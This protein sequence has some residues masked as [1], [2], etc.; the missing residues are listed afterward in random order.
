MQSL[1]ARPET[2]RPSLRDPDEGQ[3][4]DRNAMKS[5]AKLG[6]ISEAVGNGQRR[7]MFESCENYFQQDG[8]RGKRQSIP[9]V[10][11]TDWL[12]GLSTL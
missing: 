2:K 10:R 8:S 3:L 5:V 11:M 1:R 6:D 9:P 12:T 7:R 4:P